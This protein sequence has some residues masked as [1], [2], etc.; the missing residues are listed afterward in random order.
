MPYDAFR[1]GREAFFV[2]KLRVV[3]NFFHVQREVSCTTMR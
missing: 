1:P 2:Y 3:C